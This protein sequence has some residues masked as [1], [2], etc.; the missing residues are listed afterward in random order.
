MRLQR[1]ML[2][3]AS[4][5][6]ADSMQA[7]LRQ[8]DACCAVLTGLDAGEDTRKTLADDATADEPVHEGVRDAD[9]PVNP[10]GDSSATILVSDS[11]ARVPMP[12]VGGARYDQDRTLAADP[13]QPPLALAA[14]DSGATCNYTPAE[15]LRPAPVTDPSS[16]ANSNETRYHESGE[17]RAG[18]RAGS[19]AAPARPCL[20]AWWCRDM[21]FWRNSA[22][23]AWAW[24]TRPG[25]CGC[26]AWLR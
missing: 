16:A 8:C 24:S 21:R 5:T 9:R 3:Q 2:G 11:S 18:Q 19:Q 10:P 23:A 1:F 14:G 13:M 15:V 26:S 6:E 22:V 12:A 20:R 25:T 7:H 4:R 17:G